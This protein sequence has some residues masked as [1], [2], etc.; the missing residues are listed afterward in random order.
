MDTLPPG[1]KGKANLF[2]SWVWGYTLSVLLESLRAWAE[3]E[4]EKQG[5]AFDA[6]STYVARRAAHL[7]WRTPPS[8]E[9]KR[10]PSTAASHLNVH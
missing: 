8:P 7:G 3:Q 2:C 9:Q 1:S 6:S 4:A 10:S 5:P